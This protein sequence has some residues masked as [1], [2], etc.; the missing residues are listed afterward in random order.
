MSGRRFT[1]IGALKQWL[2]DHSMTVPYDSSI[3]NTLILNFSLLE[4]HLLE[5]EDLRRNIMYVRKCCPAPAVQQLEALCTQPHVARLW[6]GPEL[7]ETCSHYV[8][9]LYPALCW[10]QP[11]QQSAATFE[12]HIRRFIEAIEFERCSVRATLWQAAMDEYVAHWDHPHCPASVRGPKNIRHPCLRR[13]PS[14]TLCPM[15]KNARQRR[16][17]ILRAVTP[18]PSDLLHLME[19][20]AQ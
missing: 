17:A 13:R 18:L 14:H 4:T 16:Q 2:R 19:R 10:C 1:D 20:Y 15:H 12:R 11:S 7:V 5:D 9:I 3:A 8:T 6:T